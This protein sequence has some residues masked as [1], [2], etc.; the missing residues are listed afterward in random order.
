MA[1]CIEAIADRKGKAAGV[2][3]SCSALVNEKVGRITLSIIQSLN[4]TRS[5]C[6]ADYFEVKYKIQTYVDNDIN[7]LLTAL[8]MTSEKIERTETMLCVGISESAGMSFIAEGMLYRGAHNLAGN[9]LLFDD[10]PNMLAIK[11]DIRAFL[12]DHPDFDRARLNLSANEKLS[13]RHIQYALQ[14]EDPTIL[15]RLIPFA[16]QIGQCI[17][18]IEQLLDAE[19]IVVFCPIFEHG[20]A[21]FERVTVAFCEKAFE[22]YHA[23][24]F[25]KMPLNDEMFAV[26]AAKYAYR[27]TFRLT[28]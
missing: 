12:E 4:D 13:T 9:L 23:V 19:Y 20:D 2:G 15:S 25:V 22:P 11:R 10:M 3:I 18:K 14:H 24:K 1:G 17:A 5:M 6:L 7:M 27:M 28:S 16:T 26:S 8:Q 21:L